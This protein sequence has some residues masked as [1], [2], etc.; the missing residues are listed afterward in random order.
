MFRQ[1]RST[2]ARAI[3]KVPSD[4]LFVRASA[5]PQR[6]W[7]CNRA[8]LVVGRVRKGQ[9]H[10]AHEGAVAVVALAGKAMA[11]AQGRRR[12]V[13]DVEQAVTGVSVVV[14]LREELLAN[15][16]HVNAPQLAVAVADGKRHRGVVAPRARRLVVR[17]VARHA[18]ARKGA[19]PHELVRDA[20]RVADE[21]QPRCAAQGFGLRAALGAT[22]CK[23][24][25]FVQRKFQSQR[26]DSTERE[27]FEAL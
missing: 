22:S 4:P 9:R 15:V 7:P 12:Y 26:L 25:V 13:A 16:A 17:A 6:L 2:W 21:D 10:S 19:A 23:V 14:V 1:A 11:D 3:Y 5:E 24:L 27:V 18:R 8:H 20:E